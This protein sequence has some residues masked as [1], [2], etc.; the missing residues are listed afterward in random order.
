[1]DE[2][3]GLPPLYARWLADVVAG[4]IPSETEATCGHCAMVAQDSVSEGFRADAKCCTYLPELHN[5]LVGGILA[6]PDPAMAVGRASVADRIARRMAVTPLG[7]G[8]PRSYLLLYDDGGSV[9]FGRSRALRCPH[10]VDETGRC[11][12]WRYRESTCATWFC[13]HVRGRTGQ[14]FWQAVRRML[15]IVER[16]LAWWC[17]AQ[18]G[19]DVATVAALLTDREQARKANRQVTAAELDG[20]AP[21]HYRELWGA[22]LD[23]EH[24]LYMA[25][26]EMVT[27][28]RWAQVMRIAGPQADAA[29]WVV[30]DYYESLV[31]DGL[32]DKLVLGSFR[33]LGF[34]SGTCTISAYSDHDPVA[35]PVDLMD[36]LRGFD[37]RNVDAVLGELAA[38]GIE[39]E[40]ELVL[41]LV[42]LGVLVE[43]AR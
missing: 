41:R 18:A 9:T 23:R 36:A 38:Q 1:M 11:G 4:P 12:V 14:R 40:R 21:R 42:D 19:I 30:R 20:L 27:D 32:P 26:A 17:L 34:A 25:C 3:D 10:F 33:T 24:E 5:F 43:P 37:G 13:K 22:W 35:L 2:M 28:L 7:L 31:S 16:D 8:Q 15:A 39:L 6:D 29:A